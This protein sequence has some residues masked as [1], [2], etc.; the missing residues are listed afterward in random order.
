MDENGQLLSIEG[1]LSAELWT[2]DSSEVLLQQWDN[3]PVTKD[4][5][6]DGSGH[7]VD[8]EY[9]DF[10][11]EI[12]FQYHILIALTVGSTRLTTERVL[13]LIPPPD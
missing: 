9:K 1:K 13:Q 11:P 3:V 7:D 8:L 2:T 5:F 6:I 10:K 12:G 4:S